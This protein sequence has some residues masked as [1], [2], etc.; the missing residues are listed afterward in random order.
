MHFSKSYFTPETL[1]YI[2]T[3]LVK[4]YKSLQKNSISLTKYHDKYYFLDYSK[5]NI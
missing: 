3:T 2:N 4:Y 1:K 5:I